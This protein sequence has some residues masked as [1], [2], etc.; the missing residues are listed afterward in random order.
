MLSTQ[1]ILAE[2]AGAVPLSVA[3]IAAE[4]VRGKRVVLDVSGANDTVDQLR[5]ILD[6]H[7]GH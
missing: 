1:H 7:S 4:R 3:H 6:R 5:A 2:P